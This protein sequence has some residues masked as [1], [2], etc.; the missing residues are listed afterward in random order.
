MRLPT[1]PSSLLAPLTPLLLA[2]LAPAA[3]AQDTFPEHAVERARTFWQSNA[4]APDHMDCITTLNHAIRLLYSDP[5]LTLGSQIDHT[6]EALRGRGLASARRDVEFLNEAGKPTTGVTAPDRLR[7]SVWGVMRGMTAGQAGWSVFG[8][9]LMDGYHSVALVLDQRD[10]AAP[11]VYWCDQWSSNGGWRQHDQQSLDAEIERLTGNWW[12]DTKKP[13][14]R[15][16]LWR[17]R[18]A[19]VKA[20]E[21]RLRPGLT[22]LNLRAGPGTNTEILGRLRPAD[23]LE[24]VDFRPGWLQLR[25]ADGSRVWASQTYLVTAR[26]TPLAPAPLPTPTASVTA[27]LGGIGD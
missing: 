13:R 26:V 14:T 2:A 5:D 15:A 8:L 11:K 1:R 27:V 9:S 20:L 21:A 24:M 18:G 3:L 10:P 19:G 4:V 16:T 12:S 23:R 22:T 7:E 25:R 17:L 6:M